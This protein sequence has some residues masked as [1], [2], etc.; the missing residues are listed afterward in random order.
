MGDISKIVCVLF[1]YALNRFYLKNVIVIPAISYILKCHFN[2]FLGG[3]FII[4]YINL[5]LEHSN[6]RHYRVDTVSMAVTITIICGIFWEY[7]APFFLH[8]GVSDVY[9]VIAYVLGGIT[10]LLLW[11]VVPVK[12]NWYS[13]CWNS[14]ISLVTYRGDFY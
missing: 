4:A 6:Y 1:L 14:S 5:I 3:I 11:R 9:D 10:Y 2:D 8:Q 7:V 12:I 13:H